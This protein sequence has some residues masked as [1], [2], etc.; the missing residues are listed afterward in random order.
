[1]IKLETFIE[2]NT[3][4]YKAKEDVM[5]NLNDYIKK[6]GISRADILEFRTDCQ[7]SNSNRTFT[8][9]VTISW[10]SYEEEDWEK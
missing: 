10:W 4:R 2:L 1:M 6:H 9:K 3:N 5:K 7:Y 8:Y